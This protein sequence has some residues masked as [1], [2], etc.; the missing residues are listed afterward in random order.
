MTQPWPVQITALTPAACGAARWRK[1]G[2]S[3]VTVIVKATF[4]LVH[5][6][7]ATLT[8]P[9]EIVRED[10]YRERTGSL[11]EASETAP[12]LPTAGVLLAGHAHAPGGRAAPT[13]AARL[14]I[15]RERPLL[16]KTVHVFGDRA[17]GASHA[18]PFVKM[19]L[20]YER[21]YGGAGM[22]ENPVG[23]GIAG[24]AAQPNVLDTTSSQRPELVTGVTLGAT[25]VTSWPLPE[26]TNAGPPVAPS[27]LTVPDP[28][29]SASASGRVVGVPAAPKLPPR[30]TPPASPTATA[31]ASTPPPKRSI[32]KKD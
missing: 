13:A 17:S 27:A 2:T 7:L 25:G 29:T 31:K 24:T 21:A 18:Q 28:A 16:D 22:A 3:W 4:D 23:M 5:G 32:L 1:A 10:R 14:A 15:V 30:Q 12:Y 8:T 9:R 26:S 6:Q 11:E 20:V 19:P